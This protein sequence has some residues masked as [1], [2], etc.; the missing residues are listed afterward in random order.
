MGVEIER[1]FLIHHDRLPE[2]FFGEAHSM[3]IEQAYLT[4]DPWTRVRIVQGNTQK[5]VLTIKGKG[6]VKRTEVNCQIPMGDAK[7]L[8]DLAK[9]GVI[10][11]I[12]HN[13]GPWEVDEF[14]D[15][16]AG[17]WLAEIELESEDTQFDKPVWI[18]EEV[19]EDIRYT[20]AYLAEHGLPGVADKATGLSTAHRIL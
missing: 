12:R 7:D 2:D 10:R 6:T 1:R 14:T 16:H 3:M 19:T 18:G 20:N 9:F 8:W 11:K 17:L 5:A 13:Y 4:K 15:K